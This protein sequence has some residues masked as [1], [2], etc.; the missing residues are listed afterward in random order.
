MQANW[1]DLC[2]TPL[3]LHTV[4]ISR[5]R[6][7]VFC[8]W[9]QGEDSPTYHPMRTEA[10]ILEMYAVS[11]CQIGLIIHFR[12]SPVKEFKVGK[13]KQIIVKNKSIWIKLRILPLPAKLKVEN[14][15]FCLVKWNILHLEEK[16]S[17]VSVTFLGE[18]KGFL[19][20]TEVNFKISN[21]RCYIAC[22]LTLTGTQKSLNESGDLSL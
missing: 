1:R 20:K 11:N 19:L 6:S 7:K 16:I 15:Y 10:V 5:E 21:L 9:T 3:Q 18:T 22:I 12:R 8:M 14:K 17:F 13:W 2:T 4:N